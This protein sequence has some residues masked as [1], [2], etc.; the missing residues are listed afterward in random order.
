MPLK[1]QAAAH[2]RESVVRYGK[3]LCQ[4]PICERIHGQAPFRNEEKLA[5][6]AQMVLERETL[7]K[8][9]SVNFGLR[10]CS[11]EFPVRETEAALPAPEAIYGGLNLRAAG[12]GLQCD[13]SG[14]ERGGSRGPRYVP[15]FFSS[16]DVD[17]IPPFGVRA[18]RT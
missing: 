13:V 5:V 14:C 4:F 6:D 17:P 3:D 8:E 12:D 2:P 15:V 10:R 7:S 18:E 16:I 9:R 1:F 11:P